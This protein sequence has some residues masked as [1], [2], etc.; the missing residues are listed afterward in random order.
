MQYSVLRDDDA[1]FGDSKLKRKYQ[2]RVLP[3]PSEIRTRGVKLPSFGQGLYERRARKLQLERD[4]LLAKIESLAAS[5][6]VMAELEAVQSSMGERTV[7]PV[8]GGELQDDIAGPEF[9][10]EKRL[11]LDSNPVYWSVEQVVDFIKTT[12]ARQFA[13]T[14]LDQVRPTRASSR[15]S[16]YYLDFFNITEHIVVHISFY[17]SKSISVYL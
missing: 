15:P 17:P 13:S 7:S 16:R 5:Q 4:E 9:A 12:D 2:R 6:G 3:P 10:G 11:R 1:A 14:L 8:F